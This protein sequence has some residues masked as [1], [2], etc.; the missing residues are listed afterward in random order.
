M[1]EQQ[2]ENAEWNL[3]DQITTMRETD[4]GARILVPKE[5]NKCMDDMD[6]VYEQQPS[7]EK[8]AAWLEFHDY[9]RICKQSQNFPRKLKK[10]GLSCHLAA[11]TLVL[12]KNAEKTLKQAHHLSNATWPTLSTALA[13][14]IWSSSYPSTRNHFH[15]FTN[16]LV[17]CHHCAPV[18]SDASAFLV[19]PVT[20]P[21]QE[22]HGSRSA[23]TRPLQC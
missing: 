9:C 21:I 6:D 5:E 4:G 14:S 12:S 8:Q 1:T 13:I 10:E 3:V 23:I 17:A 11:S 15:S 22:E 20:S 2:Y 19:L 7:S 16:W 18:K